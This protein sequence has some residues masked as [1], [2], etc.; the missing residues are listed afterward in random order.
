[1]VCAAGYH[2]VALVLPAFAQAA[3]PPGYPVWRHILFVM[4]D[5][6]FAGFLVWR[7]M[8]LIWPYTVLAVQ[9][10]KGHGGGAWTVWHRG[11][12]ITWTFWINL[13][14]VV[15]V[16]QGFW[17]LFMDWCERRSDGIQ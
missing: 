7:P 10:I 2:C 15:G 16:L 6:I 4:I 1:M 11:G 14:T 13:A 9:Q 12:P 17:L 8:W 5:V 3:Y